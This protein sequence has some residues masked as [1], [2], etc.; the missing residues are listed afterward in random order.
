MAAN[1]TTYLVETKYV[2]DVAKAKPGLDAVTQGAHRASGALGGLKQHFMAL[3]A[4]ALGGGFLIA[5]KKSF[6]DF[7]SD[8]EQLQIRMAGLLDIS[9]GGGLERRLGTAKDLVAEL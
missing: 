1:V 4:A 3:G 8:M 5:A 2:T 6:V 7:N 9:V